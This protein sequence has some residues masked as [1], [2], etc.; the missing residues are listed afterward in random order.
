MVR[1]SETKGSEDLR[2]FGLKKFEQVHIRTAA[3]PK[4]MPQYRNPILP[5]RGPVLW[6]MVFLSLGFN[7]ENEGRI[8][9]LIGR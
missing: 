2:S 9:C 6:I 4:T 3:Q 5:L 8:R 7:G 1:L